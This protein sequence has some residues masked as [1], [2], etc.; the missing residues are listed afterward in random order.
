MCK[1]SRK[2]KTG[3]ACVLALIL[4]AVFAAIAV[5]FT[6]ASSIVAAKAD[7]TANSQQARLEAEGGIAF[8]SRLLQK[9]GVQGGLT[10]TAMMSDLYASMKADV[11]TGNVNAAGITYDGTGFINIPAIWTDPASSIS[12]RLIKFDDT[13]VHLAVTGQTG[14]TART[15]SLRYEVQPGLAAALNYGVASRGQ[16]ALSGNV[17]ITG[18]TGHL[19]WG[20]VLSAT[21][22]TTQAITMG[23]NCQL[24]GDA[25]VSNS[26]GQVV[27]T[28]S[29]TVGGC[30]VGDPNLG[31]HIHIGVGDV[32][33]PQPDPSVFAPYA[34]SIVD[35]HTTVTGG[36]T[37]TNIRI[38]AGTNPRFT[39]NTTI[40]GV[41]Y[42]EKPNQVTFA[43][44]AIINGVV[45]TDDATS[46]NDLTSNRISFSGN[47]TFRG[48]DTL[49]DQPIYQGLRALTGT[50][51]LA[52]GFD[53]SFGGNFGTINGTLA[54]GQFVWGGNAGG[55]VKGCVINWSDSVFQMGGN[56]LITIDRSGGIGNLPGLVS[57]S[58]LVALSSTY[59]SP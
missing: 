28:G 21:H 58:V 32:E 26:S 1:R 57:R 49:P 30:G 6:C 20:S 59:Q 11:G 53:V 42:I 25:S 45:V 54:A 16:I 22:S 5:S 34:T 35:S 10:G 38:K 15:A 12:A 2:T 41:M 29:A 23:G 55:T 18:L 13:H 7:N 9:A 40:N 43:G 37:F 31:Q 27:M 8:Y 46:S 51:V 24:S 56:A 47:T 17:D 14:T 4:L 52:P 48:V 19:G 50:A 3:F 36:R 44:N 39:G 33:F